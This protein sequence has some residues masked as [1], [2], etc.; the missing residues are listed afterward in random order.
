MT[1]NA[2]GATKMPAN[3][4][5]LKT[6]VLVAVSSYFAYS[7]YWL[8]KS[9]QWMLEI[10]L[11]P[12]NYSPSAGLRFVDSYS[13]SGAYVMEFSGFLGLVLRVIGASYAL[14]ATVMLFKDRPLFSSSLK[15]KIS[16]ALFLEALY[17][18]SFVPAIYYLLDLSVLPSTSRLFLSAG[19]SAQIV[20]ISPL[21]IFLS[22]KLK[23]HVLGM[24][25][26][27]LSRLAV[28]SCLSYIIALWLIYIFK[29]AEMSALEGLN[30]LL[31]P[32]VVIAFLNTGVTLSL[33][34]IFA[35]IGT[36]L[37]RGKNRR[38]K[39]MKWWGLSAVFLSMHLII[40]VLYCVNYGVAWMAQYG[41]LWV[42]PFLG[43]GIYLLL[44]N[45]KIKS[46]Q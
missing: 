10:S 31:T 32:P 15:N 6:S 11:R 36:L 34:V 9:F 5:A 4:F 44:K 37:S 25:E 18:F 45:P 3:H 46:V 19:F 20:L 40:Y 38:E 1:W 16:N 35:V 24:G 39:A 43:L 7:L 13:L 8:T 14:I 28:L 22:L 2:A 17:F 21:L 30:W 12:E 23:K 33:S 42:I 41:E 26:A 27:S 29:W